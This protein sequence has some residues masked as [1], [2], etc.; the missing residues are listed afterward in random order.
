MIFRMGACLICVLLAGGA[1]GSDLAVHAG[2]SVG[3]SLGKVQAHRSDGLEFWEDDWQKFGA[4][5]ALLGAQVGRVVIRFEPA[6]VSVGAPG[7]LPRGGP[8]P[9]GLR[10]H[11]LEWPL[12]LGARIGPTRARGWSLVVAGG[13]SY[14]RRVGV[15]PGSGYV[16]YTRSGPFFLYSPTQIE[17]LDRNDWGLRVAVTAERH[18]GRVSPLVGVQHTFGLR[19]LDRDRDY[20]VVTRRLDA[21]VGVSLQARRRPTTARP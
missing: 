13:G 15:S 18:G 4:Y 2:A 10:L 11:Y 17:R 21:Y 9:E 12:M 6:F 3:L 5:R 7:D 14:A 1:A 8:P 16:T 19:D 20:R